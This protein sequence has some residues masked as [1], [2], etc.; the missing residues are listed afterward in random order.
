[1]TR[2]LRAARI[3]VCAALLAPTTTLAQPQHAI[4]MYGEPAL[5]PDFVA[6][7]YANPDAPKGGTVRLGETGGFDS[8]NPFILKGRAPWPVQTMVLETLMG[9]N[10][11]EP[12]TLYGLLAESIETGPNRE[13][14]EFTLRPEAKFS[15]GSSVTVEDV[16]WS[17]QTLTEKGLPRYANAWTKVASVEQTGERSVRFVF[18]AADAE[19]PLIIGLRP[20][21]KKADWGSVDFAESTLRRPIGSGPYVIGEFEPGRYVNFDRD[22]DYWGKDLPLN[23]G[24]HNFDR[25]R[26]EYFID[27]GVL[28]Q[29]FTAGELS[30]YR[31]LDPKRW[32]T[33]YDFPAVTSGR[34]VKSEIPHGRPSGM[35]GFVFNT[36][37]PIFQDWRVRDALLHAFNFEFVNATLNDGAFPRRAS[38]FANSRLAM[39]QGPAEG[40]VRALLEP[41]AAD[42]PPDALDAYALP[43]SDGNQR[44]R[45]NMR[46]ATRLLEEA[47]WKSEGGVLRDA[48]GNPFTFEIL[49]QAG[50]PT[51]SSGN[52]EAIANLYVDA[53]RQLGAQASVKVVDQAQFTERRNAYDYDMIVGGWAMSL[54]PGNE[55]TLYFGSAG[56]TTPGT[57]NYPGIASPAAEAMI[58]GL[59]ATRDEAEFVAATQALDRVLTTGRYVIPFW[60]SDISRIAHV[61]QMEFPETLPVYGDWTGWM[62]DVW[63]WRE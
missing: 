57:R 47:G 7:P 62:P 32:A 6:L 63:W 12:F 15:D 3:A 31:E 60:F 11:D 50:Q 54:S 33:G 48:G 52:V 43:A 34:V 35:E 5:P 45:A 37:R 23:R 19:L 58:A 4:A 14:V 36:R 55:Q 25:V 1:M 20:I 39:G 13:W 51:L 28:F 24:V 53:L 26:Y 44:N 40:R 38:Y 46:A 9:R 2:L 18:N 42:L 41:F 22:P 61:S 29:A 49:V 30:A 17:M 16:I 59:L 27:A 10:W 21:L 56:V 8:L